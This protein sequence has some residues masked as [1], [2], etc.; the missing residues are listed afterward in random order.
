MIIIYNILDTRKLTLPKKDSDRCRF[1]LLEGGGA[2]IKNVN[3]VIGLRKTSPH[4]VYIYIY[5]L[6]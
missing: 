1:D 5:I 4:I 3:Q 6:Q 2:I